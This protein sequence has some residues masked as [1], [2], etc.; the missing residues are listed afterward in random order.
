MSDSMAGF[1][2]LDLDLDWL[3]LRCITGSLRPLAG[4]INKGVLRLCLQ[5]AILKG[6][7]KPYKRKKA[8]RAMKHTLEH[9]IA[10]RKCQKFLSKIGG[11]VDVTTSP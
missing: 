8:R 2:F 11:F 5:Y 4:A 6:T 7:Q 1:H 9:K 10:C 3:L